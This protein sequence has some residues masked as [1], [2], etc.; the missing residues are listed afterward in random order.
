[1]HYLEDIFLRHL[2]VKYNDIA[3]EI[4]V[5]VE[6]YSGY[7]VDEY[8]IRFWIGEM[9]CEIMEI[10]DR[11]YS[12]GYTYFKVFADNARHYILKG[13]LE[14]NSWILIEVQ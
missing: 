5:K 2:A 13:P 4:Q 14:N 8:P 6:T 12:P 7:M 3:M 1:M 9:P 11:W 10:E